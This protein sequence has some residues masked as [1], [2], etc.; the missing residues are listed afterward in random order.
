MRGLRIQN[1]EIDSDPYPY[2]SEAVPT[3]ETASFFSGKSLFLFSIKKCQPFGV[4]L[5]KK[6]LL[7]FNNV[8]PA[9]A[10]RLFGI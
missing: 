6:Q 7:S 2:K 9:T 5:Q 3:Y 10:G 1:S 8:I 4:T